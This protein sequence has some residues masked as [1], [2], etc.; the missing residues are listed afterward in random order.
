[1]LNGNLSMSNI[2]VSTGSIRCS[3]WWSIF[4]T[5]TTNYI[6]I[7]AYTM[8]SVSRFIHSYARLCLFGIF[9]SEHSNVF[10][11]IS[12][13]WFYGDPHIR[14]LDGFQYTF[15]GLGEY[16]LIETT[17]GNFTLQ[18][19]T[20]KA[21]DDNGT[22]RTRP[23][24]VRSLLETSTQTPSTWGWRPQETVGRRLCIFMLSVIRN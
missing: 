19:R 23:C 13:G 4:I 8:I 15:N 22:K 18:G 3:I 1:M 24:S 14:T 17:H 5:Y 2:V 10:I 12:A 16:I 7:C 9:C 11:P 20:A 21:R 6:S